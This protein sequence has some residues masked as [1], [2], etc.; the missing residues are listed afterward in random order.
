M[1]SN[2]TPDAKEEELVR[3]AAAQL[4]ERVAEAHQT[5]QEALQEFPVRPHRP[6]AT[7]IADFMGGHEALASPVRS[8]M[9]LHEVVQSGIPNQ[10]LFQLADALAVPLPV[11]AKA[12][13]ISE[14]KLYIIE[15]RD[16]SLDAAVG[17][18]LCRVAYLGVL[19]TQVFSDQAAAGRWL[20]EA[21]HGLG[22][23]IPLDLTATYA[24]TQEA[25]ALLM[26][27][28]HSFYA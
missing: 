13:A 26:R 25:E 21:Q 3:E 28:R 8:M 22:D 15:G 2:E 14:T 23:R 12:L 20:I 1:S 9:D 6:T 4:R 24:G 18:R 27:L 10:A 19:A 5:V 7:Q 17:D 16:D 11:F